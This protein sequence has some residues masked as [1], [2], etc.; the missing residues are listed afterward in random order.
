M[1]NFNCKTVVDIKLFFLKSYNITNTFSFSK[2]QRDTLHKDI[3]DIY[4]ISLTHDYI[5]I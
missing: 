5:C 2:E 3:E 1:A 4:I